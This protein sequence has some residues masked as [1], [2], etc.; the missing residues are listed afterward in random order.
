[1]GGDIDQIVAVRPHAEGWMASGRAARFM[2]RN[3][4]RRHEHRSLLAAV[5][6]GDAL[7]AV[8]GPQ[9]FGHATAE[10]ED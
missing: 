5:E 6:D 2:R 9:N 10:I 8:E 7:I 1:M 3:A 4:P